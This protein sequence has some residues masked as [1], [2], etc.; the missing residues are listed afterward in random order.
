MASDEPESSMVMNF[1]DD[2]MQSA[3]E[4]DLDS[5]DPLGILNMAVEA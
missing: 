2:G 1:V 4:I 3:I 5:P